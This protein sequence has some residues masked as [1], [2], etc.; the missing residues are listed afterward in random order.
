[1]KVLLEKSKNQQMPIE[2]I[3]LSEKGFLSQRT[4][5]VNEVNEHYIKAYCF[6]KHQIRIFK[7]GNILSAA[8]QKRKRK[9]A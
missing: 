4:I 1:M 6:S 5:I 7:T 3:Y 9:F 2:M 8:I